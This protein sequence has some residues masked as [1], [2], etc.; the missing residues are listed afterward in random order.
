MSIKDCM[1]VILEAMH[2]L[3]PDKLAPAHFLKD[4]NSLG[5]T[6]LHYFCYTKR[7][8]TCFL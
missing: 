1:Y 3:E 8:S 2:K 6:I 7:L 4:A 5:A